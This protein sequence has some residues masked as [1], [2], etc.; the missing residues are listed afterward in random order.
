MQRLQ[1]AGFVYNPHAENV[2]VHR[3]RLP[4][5]M[6]VHQNKWHKQNKNNFS[7]TALCYSG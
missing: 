6:L 7:F 5:A 2:E 1:L 4:N 3:T